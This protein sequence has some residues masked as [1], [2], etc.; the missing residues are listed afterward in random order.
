MKMTLAMQRCAAWIAF[1][2]ILLAA[3]AP[4]ISHALASHQTEPAMLEIC[5]M[6]GSKMIQVDDHQNPEPSHHQ[7]SFDHFE[8]CP[9]C[10][11][12]S[13][14]TG[15]PATTALFVATI[16][17]RATFPALFY[18]A[19]SGLYVWTAASPRAPPAFS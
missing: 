15:L 6:D 14:A 7:Q 5:T 19:P 13:V 12:N 9:F 11:T 16:A 3:L 17:Q 2:A 8:H 1:C 10:K 4:S 18:Q